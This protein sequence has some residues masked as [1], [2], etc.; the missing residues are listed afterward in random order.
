M[1]LRG[2]LGDEV[3]VQSLITLATRPVTYQPPLPPAPQPQVLLNGTKAG[4]E[5]QHSTVDSGGTAGCSGNRLQT[6][7]TRSSEHVPVDMS[8]DVLLN[9]LQ[10]VMMEA[11]RGELVLT[12]HPRTIILPPVSAR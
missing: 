1:Y 10:N 7:T 5:E 8:E 3:F 12:V 9:T 6:Q 2:I 4:L 11:V